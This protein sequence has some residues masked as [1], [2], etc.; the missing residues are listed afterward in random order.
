M[1]KDNLSDLNINIFDEIYV[2]T[3][4]RVPFDTENPPL[5]FATQTGTGFTKRKDTVDTWSGP[6]W[7]HQ[8]V[9][10][11]KGDI[12]KDE[13]GVYQQEKIHHPK[14]EGH[15]LP[16]EPLGGFT[17]EKSVSRWST[18]NKWFTINDPRGFQLQIAA[19][20]LG[21]ILINAGVLN[22]DLQGEYVWA[23]NGST[24]FLCRTS[25]PAYIDKIQPKIARTNL[26]P[27]DVILM[28]Q[29]TTEF[30]FLG[31]FYTTRLGTE[32]RY[33]EKATGK[34][35]PN[36][37]RPSYSYYGRERDQYEQKGVT[38]S[39]Q[40][41]KLVYVFKYGNGLKLMRQKPTKIKILRAGD[42]FCLKVGQ[43]YQIWTNLP[44]SDVALFWD[45]VE[46]MKEN[47]APFVQFYGDTIRDAKGFGGHHYNRE[48]YRY[49]GDINRDL[50]NNKDQSL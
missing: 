42:P 45:T 50:A 37:F 9:K 1:S 23:R 26:I 46:D 35:M 47:G 16:N 44:A 31:T 25:H 36:D 19:D 21:D 14:T 12:I 13:K 40:D 4:G 27:G 30:E 48:S 6:E 43:P 34:I 8:Y 11:E 24:I 33:I 2:Q 28:G 10:D 49:G 15:Y 3:R 18:S 29:D 41:D 32:Y 20:N 22:G 38:F 7:T 5:A 39:A 17:F